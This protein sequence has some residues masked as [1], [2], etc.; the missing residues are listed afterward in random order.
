MRFQLKHL[1][2]NIETRNIFLIADGNSCKLTNGGMAMT[3]E[4]K[5]LFK[6]IFKSI[7]YNNDANAIVKRDTHFMT[8]FIIISM[9]NF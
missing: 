4:N 9:S 6:I 5:L 2:R 8:K 1:K 7:G 3:T